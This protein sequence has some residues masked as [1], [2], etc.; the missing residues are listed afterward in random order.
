MLPSQPNV[1]AG[2]DDGGLVKDVKPFLLID[3]AFTKLQNAYVWRNRVKKR[4]GLELIGR[5]RRILTSQVLPVTSN[6]D[7]Y[8]VADILTSLSLRT[9][10][11]DGEVEPGSLVITIDSGGA[12]ETIVEDSSGNGIL[13]ATAT[14]NLGFTTG[15]IKYITGEIY[16]NFSGV[17]SA[18]LTVS[19][20]LGYY[21]TLPV[22]GIWQRELG[23]INNEQ[24]VFWDTVFDYVNPGTGFQQLTSTVWAGTDSDFFSV[25]NFRGTNPYDRLFFA[26]NFVNTAANP[27]RYF[28][29]STWTTFAPLVSATDTLFQ[30]KILVPY[31]GRL[32]AL[33][34]WEGTTVGTP[35]AANNYFSRCRFSQVGNPI[36]SDAWRSD[37]F[38]K[39]GFIDAPTNEAIVGATFFKNTLLVQFERSTWQLRYVGEYGLPFIWER[40]SSDFGAESGFSTVLFDSGVL[41]V[42]DRAIVTGNSS[43]VNRIDEQIPDEVFS[44]SNENDGPQRVIGIRDFQKELVYWCYSSGEL[45]RKF[46]NHTLLYNYKNNTFAEFRNNVTFFGTYQDPVGITWDSL[47]TYWYED[48]VLWDDDP[49]LI[50]LFPSIVCGNQKGYI[51]KYSYTNLDE[52]SLPVKGITFPVDV[53]QPITLNIPDHNLENEEIIYL[54]DFKF[55][56][57]SDPTDPT[58]VGTNLN[59]RIF[60]VT[61]IDDDNI[62]LSEWVQPDGPYVTDYPRSPDADA[63]YIGTGQVTLFP[64]MYIEMKDF[65]PYAAQGNQLKIT[66]IDFLTD[67]P[68]DDPAINV[69]MSINIFVNTSL[70]FKGNAI[71]SNQSGSTTT[72]SPYY[73]LGS[74]YVWHRFYANLNGQ[75]I[76]IALTYDDAL[77]NNIN[78]HIYQWVLNSMII[79]SRPGGKTIFQVLMAF[80]SDP[81]LLSN[82]LPISLDLPRGVETYDEM[83]E[84]LELLYKRIANAVNTKEGGQYQPRELATFEQ[85]PLR[86]T[87]S[88][89][90]YLPNQFVNIYR[91]IVDFGALPNATTKSVPHGIAFNT[92]CKATRTYIEATD[93]VNLLYIQIPFASP[94]LNENIKLVVDGTN[95]NV[96]TA[97]DYSAFTMCNVVIEFSKN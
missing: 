79:Y 25:A 46:P 90:P 86:S 34:V 44:F 56:D 50:P 42:G 11:P 7:F 96:T 19:A 85:Y 29:G 18:G 33:N 13:V 65:N 88:P 27:M 78:T 81:A 84:K 75:F 62:S 26:T 76:R 73:V 23:F 10:A 92:Q 14:N 64:K 15:Y 9:A 51:H 4:E 35:A 53:T 60:S 17:I 61:R 5:L 48:S 49:D 52:P 39:G 31:Y 3:Q 2:Y 59:E 74:D 22:M 41:A 55:I 54:T 24:T 36:Q 77:M 20:D 68:V 45:R 1:I 38:G 70:A 63:D 67:V 72:T 28:D 91:K 32:L 93:P 30:A 47:T 71:V 66:Y 69:A 43:S 83:L 21:P 58:G 6:A 37:I 95:V 40:I 89:F 97:I 12:D 16:L 80:S 82:Q 57:T 8:T 94:T 87:V